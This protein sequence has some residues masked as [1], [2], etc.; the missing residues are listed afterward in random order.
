MLNPKDASKSPLSSRIALPVALILS[1]VF[2]IMIS[3]APPPEVFQNSAASEVVPPEPE[4]GLPESGDPAVGQE[5]EIPVQPSTAELVEFCAGHV[6]ETRSFVIFR[7]GSVVL[8]DEPS[9]DPVAEARHKLVQCAEPDARFLSE[10]TKEGDL[11]ITFKEPVFHRFSSE[12]LAALEPWLEQATPVLLS[13]GETVAVGDEWT[14]HPNAR[15]GLLARRRLLEDA[16]E[17]VP[18]KVVRARQSESVAR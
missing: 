4:P 1:G 8:V 13:P 9:E 11:I 16:T 10:P 5:A 17:A 14:P 3:L 7:R 2:G 15:V 18:V 6:T 12:E